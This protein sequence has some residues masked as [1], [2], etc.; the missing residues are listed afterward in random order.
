MS[1]LFEFFKLVNVSEQST[2]QWL[3][4]GFEQKEFLWFITTY[5]FYRHFK[6]YHT[7]VISSIYR[8]HCG[9]I[10]S[11]YSSKW[12]VSLVEHKANKT[13]ALHAHL[14]EL[15]PAYANFQTNSRAFLKSANWRAWPTDYKYHILKEKLRSDKVT[16]GQWTFE[17]SEKYRFF[18]YLNFLYLITK[19]TNQSPW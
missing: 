19:A 14:R 9:C 7:W 15:A 6:F 10:S 16:R 2:K 5:A 8:R 18:Q 1:L 4:Q 17:K 13:F 3:C 11:S 12:S